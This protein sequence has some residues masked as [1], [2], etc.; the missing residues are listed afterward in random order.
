M[1]A[2]DEVYVFRT[3]NKF[4]NHNMIFPRD[5]QTGCDPD[6]LIEEGTL[7]FLYISWLFSLKRKL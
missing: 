5:A 4:L 2:E 6:C 3:K 7:K 1:V